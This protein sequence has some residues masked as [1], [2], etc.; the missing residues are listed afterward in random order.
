MAYLD[1]LIARCAG[2]ERERWLYVV[3]LLHMC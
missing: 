2:I 1:F 3:L